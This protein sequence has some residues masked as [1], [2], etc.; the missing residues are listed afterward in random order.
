MKHVVIDFHFVH[1]QVESRQISVCHIPTGAQLADA[2][3][4]ALLRRSV[5]NFVSSIGLKQ[6]EPMLR[7]HD[8]DK[9][10]ES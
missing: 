9:D 7:G 3:T 8:K 4:K 6:I 10:V 2:L 5:V 1:D